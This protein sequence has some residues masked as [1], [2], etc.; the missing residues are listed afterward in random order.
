MQSLYAKHYSNCFKNTSLFNP[1]NLMNGH[2]Y[3]ANFT[4]EEVEA[5]RDKSPAQG[6]RAIKWGRWV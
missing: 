3:Y 4:D 5:Q 6:Y 2:Y 1:N